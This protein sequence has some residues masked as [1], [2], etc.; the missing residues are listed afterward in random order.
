LNG[1]V[2]PAVSGTP[3]QDVRR[4]QAG[5]ASRPC[6]WLMQGGRTAAQG[7]ST[8]AGLQAACSGPRVRTTSSS[9]PRLCPGRTSRSSA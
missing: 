2:S 4:T 9:C 6:I 3:M 7:S 1:R 5:T 8:W